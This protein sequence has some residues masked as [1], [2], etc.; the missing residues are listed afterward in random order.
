MSRRW[1]PICAVTAAYAVL[2]WVGQRAPVVVVPF[3]DLP[4]DGVVE[5]FGDVTGRV[6]FEG[7][8]PEP[9]WH[10]R[11]GDADVK[12]AAVC[13][14]MDIPDE[15][16]VVYRQNRGIQHVFVYL[17]RGIDQNR[18]HPTLRKAASPEVMF[19]QRNCR[20]VPHSLVLRTEQKLRI[21][22]FDSCPHNAHPFPL[23]NSNFSFVVEPSNR[24]GVIVPSFSRREFLPIGVKCDIHPWMTAWWMIVDHPYAAVTDRNGRFTIPK[25]PVGDHVFTIWHEKVGYIE[26]ELLVTISEEETTGLKDIKVAADRF[27]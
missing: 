2:W 8:V 24:M 27:R 15:S 26:K 6:V 14:A 10:A 20:F 17:R 21:R 16:L 13:A 12:D 18:I 23:M 7:P 19:D 1:C 11:K 5:A 4:D 3:E 25:L 22:S 9:K